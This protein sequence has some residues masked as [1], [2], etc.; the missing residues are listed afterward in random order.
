MK[1][2]RLRRLLATFGAEVLDGLLKETTPDEP[3][4]LDVWARASVKLA[5]RRGLAVVDSAGKRS[6]SKWV[7]LYLD[8]RRKREVTQ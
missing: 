3:L 7:R 6:V 5:M 8:D 2:E 1:Q 4:L